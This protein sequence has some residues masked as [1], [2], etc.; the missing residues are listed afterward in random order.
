[1]NKLQ[2]LQVKKLLKELDFIESDFEYRNEVIGGADLE[3]ITSINKF[4]Q[5]NP[6]LK[7]IYDRKMTEKI[8]QLMREKTPPADQVTPEVRQA[9]GSIS[10]PEIEDQEIEPKE[11]TTHLQDQQLK[12]LYRQIVKRTHPD[13]IDNKRLNDIYLKATA[14]YNQKNKIGIYGVCNEISIAYEI[15]PE[16]LELMQIEINKFQQKISFIESTYTWKWFN[17]ADGEE[18]DQLILEYIKIKIK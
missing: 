9:D 6:E 7:E 12:N 2:L 16:D 13:K 8:E 10:E 15:E 14:Y 11:S 5:D 18:K 1:M 4:L 17:L 3:F